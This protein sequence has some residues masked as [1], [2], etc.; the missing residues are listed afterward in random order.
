MCI[1]NDKMAEYE[2]PENKPL[3]VRLSDAEH[4]RFWNLMKIANSR[5]FANKSDLVRE[6]LGLSEKV[7]TSE[8]IKYFQTGEKV[9][10]TNG[11][12]KPK[13]AVA[14]QTIN[15]RQPAEAGLNFSGKPKRQTSK[16]KE[17]ELNKQMNKAIADMEKDSEK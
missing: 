3:T 5:A 15:S 4:I 11:K 1:Q 6:L 17:A 14:P 13:T 10:A 7:L 9:F 2:I 8:D 16:E 12:S